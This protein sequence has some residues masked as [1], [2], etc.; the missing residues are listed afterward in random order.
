MIVILKVLTCSPSSQNGKKTRQANSC[1][2]SLTGLYKPPILMAVALTGLFS[3]PVPLVQAQAQAQAQ[4]HIALISPF[5]HIPPEQSFPIGI[6]IKLKPGWHTYWKNAGDTGVPPKIRFELPKGVSLKNAPWPPPKRRVDKPAGKTLYSFV[7]EEEIL[8]PFELTVSRGY[9]HLELPIQLNMEWAVCKEICSVKNTNLSLTLAM[10]TSFKPHLEHSRVF[11]RHKSDI[12]TAVNLLKSEFIRKNRLLNLHFEFREPV[13]CRDIIPQSREDFAGEEPQLLKGEDPRSCRFQVKDSGSFLHRVSGLLIYKKQDKAFSIP[14]TAIEKKVFGL[15]FF[16]L[17]AFLGGLLLNIMPCVLPVIFLKLYN[18]LEL[19]EK[20]PKKILWLN[21]TYSAG[22]IVS[23]WVLAFSVMAFKSGGEALGWGF[24]LQSPLFVTLLALLF[25]L[26]GF[27]LLNLFSLPLPQKV[28]NFKGEKFLD[29]FITGVL[30]T[31]A[32]S[33]C[34]VPFMASA[35]GFAFSRSAIE[36]FVIFSC[37]GLGLSF[38]YLFLSLVPRRFKKLPFP[39][40][41]MRLIKSALAFPL[42]ITTVWLMYPLSLQLTVPSFFLTLAIFPLTGFYIWCAGSLK[43]PLVKNAAL[44]LT[45][46]LVTGVI[47]FQEKRADD[48]FEISRKAVSVSDLSTWTAFSL[49]SVLRDRSQGKNVFVALGAEWCLTCKTNERVFRNKEI[50]NFLKAHNVHLYYGDWTYGGGE[51]TE[52][53]KSYNSW[54]VPFYIL[55]KGEEKTILFPEFLL[56]GPFLKRL[57]S[58]L[59]EPPDPKSGL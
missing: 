3:F 55:Y 51:I 29:H 14:F 11:R 30:A 18:T 37:L 27:Y 20:S 42:F 26:M 19:I 57:K 1:F 48:S 28:L 45:V 44:W 23:F 5:T 12:D 38:P 17:L 32:A 9:S 34:T 49:Q 16:A 25:T 39:G 53:L 31:T 36:V 15:L 6:R 7:Y 24:H 59:G 54:G 46:A 52:F 4:H 47:A 50:K 22:V 40:R 56:S 41:K 2:R 13:Q 33:P 21:L 58:A 10:D 43:R 35:V 8:L